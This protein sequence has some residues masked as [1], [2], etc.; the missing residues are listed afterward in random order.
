MWG[1]TYATKTLIDQIA[2]TQAAMQQLVRSRSWHDVGRELRISHSIVRDVALGRWGHI[3][4]Q[5]YGYIRQLLGL[6]EED[7]VITS[8]PLYHIGKRRRKPTIAIRI[9]PE[10]H[11][12]LRAEC[13]LLNMTWDEYTNWLYMMAHPE[14]L[15]E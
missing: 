5:Q 1:C 4:W 3:S 12:L 14:P 10:T 15:S 13:I 2:A 6:P 8:Q 9:E 7:L 11:R